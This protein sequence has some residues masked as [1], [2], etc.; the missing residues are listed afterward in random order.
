MCNAD[1]PM[2]GLIK[3]I[4]FI[5]MYF[6]DLMNIYHGYFWGTSK[7]L[8]KVTPLGVKVKSFD[9]F[10]KRRTK[11]LYFCDNDGAGRRYVFSTGAPHSGAKLHAVLPDWKNIQA[12]FLKKS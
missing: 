8:L 7:V 5:N 3:Y 4:L 2:L 1:T 12:G 11:D 6:L 9:P 10:V